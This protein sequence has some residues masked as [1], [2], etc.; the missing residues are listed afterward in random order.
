MC[1][2]KMSEQEPRHQQSS[3]DKDI[4]D[5]KSLVEV[6]K[7]AISAHSLD[8][9]TAALFMVVGLDPEL[10]AKFFSIAMYTAMT[11]LEHAAKECDCAECMGQRRKV[12]QA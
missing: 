5:T 8:V 7:S 4:A 6:I 10:S 3:D 12:G 9:K 2:T 11:R 1:E